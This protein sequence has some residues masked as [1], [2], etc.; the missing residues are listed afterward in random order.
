MLYGIN[1]SNDQKDTTEL[2]YF[3]TQARL[4]SQKVK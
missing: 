4:A 1:A 3:C 2:T